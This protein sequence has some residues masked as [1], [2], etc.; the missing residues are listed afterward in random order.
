MLDR[1][2]ARS[3]RARGRIERDS[4]ARG[5]LEEQVSEVANRD[6]AH[7]HEALVELARAVVGPARPPEGFAE[8]HDRVLAEVVRDRLRRPLRIAIDRALRGLADGLGRSIARSARA[9]AGQKI[10]IGGEVVDG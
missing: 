2:F 8:L 7:A 4:S 10:V 6:G 1:A 3:A 5:A 9:S